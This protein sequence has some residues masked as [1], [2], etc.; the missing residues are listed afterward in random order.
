MKAYFLWTVVGPQLI[1]T[2]N[3]LGKDARYLS[4]TGRAVVGSQA[5]KV[6]AYEV[7]L[8]VI[9]ERYGEQVEVVMNDPEQTDQ[10][11]VLDSDGERVLNNIH[12]KELGQPIYYEP[13]SEKSEISSTK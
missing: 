6:M 13:D 10:L 5:N 11:R 1:L 12:F 2:S 8:E 9:K 3:D 4:Q 7:P